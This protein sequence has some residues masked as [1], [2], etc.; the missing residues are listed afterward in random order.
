VPDDDTDA[1]VLRLVPSADFTIEHGKV[2]AHRA[3][4]ITPDQRLLVCKACGGNVDPF[5]V[6]LQYAQKERRWRQWDAEA[7]KSYDAL[8]ELKTEEKLVR[9]RVKRQRKKTSPATAEVEALRAVETCLRK[10]KWDK[11]AKK[12]LKHLD[13]ARRLT[14]LRRMAEEE[15]DVDA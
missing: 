11:G 7:A 13:D 1:P 9:A 4:L 15:R 8:A 2:C 6:I 5:D 14:D 10:F 12:V 3:L